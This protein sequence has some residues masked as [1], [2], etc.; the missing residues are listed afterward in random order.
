MKLKLFGVF[1]LG[2]AS[3]MGLYALTN[4]LCGLEPQNQGFIK[5]VI[6]LFLGLGIGLLTKR[7]ES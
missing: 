7:V 1:A 5:A 3:G 4:L 2:M 6:G